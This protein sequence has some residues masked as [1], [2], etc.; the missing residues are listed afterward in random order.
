MYYDSATSRTVKQIFSFIQ[1]D[2]D[3]LLFTKH[4]EPASSYF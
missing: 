2:R 4:F 3:Y 1:T